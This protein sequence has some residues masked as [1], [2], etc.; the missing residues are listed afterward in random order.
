MAGSGT[1]K[2]ESTANQS[3]CSDIIALVFIDGRE[4]GST[5][6]HPGQTYGGYEIPVDRA[7]RHIVGV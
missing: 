2:V 1:I 3:H 4:W 6:V 5:I 7:G